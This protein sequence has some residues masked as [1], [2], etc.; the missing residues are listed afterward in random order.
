MPA[1][2][3][4]FTNSDLDR[5]NINKSMFLGTGIILIM[6]RFK[7]RYKLQTLRATLKTARKVDTQTHPLPLCCVLVC[8]PNLFCTHEC[9][10]ACCWSRPLVVQNLLSH[11]LCK[12]AGKHTLHRRVDV[13][14]QLSI[15]SY[16]ERFSFFRLTVLVLQLT[17]FTFLFSLPA[18]IYSFIFLLSIFVQ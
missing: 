9:V 17:H 1:I 6:L 8:S 4:C 2:K 15:S 3:F 18:L 10:P 12:C 16:T 14:P 13:A 11:L 7:V 5:I